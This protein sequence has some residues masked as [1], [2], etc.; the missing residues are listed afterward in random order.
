MTNKL[1]TISF[2]HMANA[3]DLVAAMCGIKKACEDNNA[4][5]IIYQQLNVPA[6]YYQGA[7]HPTTDKNGTMVMMN[8]K[9]R[10]STRLNSS[11]T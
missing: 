5:A 3:G 6:G 8:N 7:T 1:K 11:H 10:K 9:D 4:K 2:K